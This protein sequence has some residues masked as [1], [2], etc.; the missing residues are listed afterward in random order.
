MTIVSVATVGAASSKTVSSQ[1]NP[2]AIS[3]TGNTIS[4]DQL[5]L[6]VLGSDNIGSGPPGLTNEHLALAIGAFP[7]TKLREYSNGGGGP[8]NG[9]TVSIWAL[10]ASA[11][12]SSSTT[13]SATFDGAVRSKA[14]TMWRFSID[15]Y[16]DVIGAIDIADTNRDLSPLTIDTQV[17]SREHLFFRGMAGESALGAFT[18][19][20]SMTAMDTYGTSGSQP[21]QDIQVRGEFQIATQPSLNTTPS[22]EV[23]DWASTGIAIYERFYSPLNTTL[24]DD[25]NRADGQLVA[26]ALWSGYSFRGAGA[27]N[28]G[29]TSN[30]LAKKLNTLQAD[31]CFTVPTYGPDI[32]LQFDVPVVPTS[33]NSIMPI[34]GIINTQT[35]VASGVIVY[36]DAGIVRIG[37]RVDPNSTQTFVNSTQTVA[38]GDSVWIAIRGKRIDVYLKRS[39]SPNWIKIVSWDNEVSGVALLP[40]QGR[41]AMLVDYTVNLVRVDN[42]SG[43]TVGDS[44]WPGNG[45]DPSP[46]SIDDFNRANGAVMGSGPWTG[47]VIRSGAASDLGITS[48]QLVRQTTATFADLLSTYVIGPDVDL[49]FDIVSMP[50]SGLRL[51]FIWGIINQQ[52]ATASGFAASISAVADGAK[53]NLA[54]M[55]DAASYTTWAISANPVAAGDRLWIKMRGTGIFVYKKVGGTGNWQYV[56]DWDSKAQSVILPRAGRFGVFV[57]TGAIIDNLRGSTIAL[58]RHKVIT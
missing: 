7:M 8:G 10:V 38:S 44:S 56:I 36:I 51:R 21:G 46:V 2:Q 37:T 43:G 41:I 11:Q 58:P 35:S 13:V 30:Q 31:D 50:N 22:V 39:G 48:N 12:I 28:L 29:V 52:T 17:V 55:D 15:G 53:V 34:M 5:V 3:F 32:D 47:T 14:W 20:G 49:S 1:G 26:G 6:A 16:A 18:A 57:D 54:T 33:G 45:V 27:T 23:A 25:F 24:L 19:G 40:R 42:L 4:K 9:S